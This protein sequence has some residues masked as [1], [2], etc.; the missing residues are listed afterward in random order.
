MSER[1]YRAAWETDKRT[2]LKV[3][4]WFVFIRHKNTNGNI[5][6]ITILGKYYSKEEAILHLFKHR[7]V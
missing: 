7:Q 6:P 4:V 5:I 3:K 2:G 1:F